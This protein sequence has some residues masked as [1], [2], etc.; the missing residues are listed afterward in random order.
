MLG[1][2]PK[3]HPKEVKLAYLRLARLYHPDINSLPSAKT[4]MQAVNQ[5]YQKFQQQLSTHN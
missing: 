3:T 4:A 1:V 5:A 2:E